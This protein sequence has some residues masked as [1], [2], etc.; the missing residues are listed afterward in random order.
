MAT[1]VPQA[2]TTA[3]RRA[4]ARARTEARPHVPGLWPTVPLP[5]LL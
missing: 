5:T 2:S 1:K 3:W 4:A